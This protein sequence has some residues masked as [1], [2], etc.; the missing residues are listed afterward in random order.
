MRCRMY[1]DGSCNDKTKIGGW[2]IVIVQHN[3]VKVKVGVIEDATNNQS[4]LVAVLNALVYAVRKNVR[5]VEIVTDS[6]YVLNGATKYLD[7]WVEN[8]WNSGK[9]C[10]IKYRKQ[11][12]EV[13]KMLDSMEANGFVVRFSKVKSHSGNSL[14]ELADVEAKKAIADYIKRRK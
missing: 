4:E 8:G 3:D 10:P 1:T 6:L 9:C 2:S 5:D 7:V 13:K 11:W 12:K 14:N